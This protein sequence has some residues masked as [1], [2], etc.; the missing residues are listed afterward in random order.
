MEAQTMTAEEIKVNIDNLLDSLQLVSKNNFVTGMVHL[1]I[2]QMYLYL[3]IKD[4][5]VDISII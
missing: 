3:A 2:A 1:R 5:K 4:K